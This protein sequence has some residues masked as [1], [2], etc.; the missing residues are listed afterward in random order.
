MGGHKMPLLPNI[1]P[2]LIDLLIEMEKNKQK[3]QYERPF[4]QIPAPKVP[5]FP[6]NDQK[7]EENSEIIVLDI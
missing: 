3:I 2:E 6:K 1:P 5:N 7:N 4:L